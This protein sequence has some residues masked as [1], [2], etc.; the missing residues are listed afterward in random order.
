MRTHELGDE[1]VVGALGFGAMSVAGSYGEVDE[2]EAMATIRRAAELGVTL[3]DPADIYGD[4]LGEERLGAA[5]ADV[6][7]DVVIGTKVGLRRVDGVV[8][9]CGDPS[10]VRTACEA[11]LRRLGDEQID[12]YMLHRPD[13]EVPV[14]ETIGAMADL[15]AAGK[16]RHLGISEPSAATLRRAASTHP[17][18]AIQCEWSLWSRDLERDVAPTARE[19]GIGI[20]AFSPLGRGFLTGTLQSEAP[21][22]SRR[23]YPRFSDG[24]LEHNQHVVDEIAAFA[25]ERG[26]TPGRLALAWVLARGADVVPIPGTKRRT[27]LEDNLAALDVTI[28]ETTITELERLAAQVSGGRVPDPASVRV[29]TPELAGGERR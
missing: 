5:L 9:V 13:P 22:D 12:L 28:D 17:L 11:S 29:D 23:S 26:T 15:V 25:A 10:Y 4:G 2:V 14:E 8:K 3:F 6:R 21:S 7:G 1:L 16:V 19:L 24:H 20:I 18:A 27:Y